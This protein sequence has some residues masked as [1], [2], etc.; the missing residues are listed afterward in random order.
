MN[1]IKDTTE[2]KDI[3]L[4]FSLLWIVVIFTMVSADIVG[5]MNPGTLKDLTNGAVGF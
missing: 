1:T 3:K 4:K 5:F 2:M